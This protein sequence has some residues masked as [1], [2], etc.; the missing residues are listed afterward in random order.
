[1]LALGFALLGVPVTSQA[2]LL[3]AANVG[4]STIEGFTPSGIGSLFA[5]DGLRSPYG[6][7]FDNVGNL[8]VANNTGGAIMRFTPGGVGSVFASTGLNVPTFIAIIPEPSTCALFALGIPAWFALCR[9]QE[10]TGT[11]DRRRR[12]RAWICHRRA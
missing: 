2:D 9:Y 8:Y 7:A 10:G 6:M 11:K 5:S 3:Y 12:S 1:M 4:N